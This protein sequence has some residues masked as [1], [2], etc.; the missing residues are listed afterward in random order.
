MKKPHLWCKTEVG[1]AF[2]APGSA[3]PHEAVF[4]AVALLSLS[5]HLTMVQ[6]SGGSVCNVVFVSEQDPSKA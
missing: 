5:D 3:R 4:L 2:L 6:F 1:A